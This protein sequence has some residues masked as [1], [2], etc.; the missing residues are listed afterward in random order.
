MSVNL[1]NFMYTVSA[2]LTNKISN[3]SCV[4]QYEQYVCNLQ[5]IVQHK[6]SLLYEINLHVAPIGNLFPSIGFTMYE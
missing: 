2:A 6:D 1:W 4:L 5:R 3:E